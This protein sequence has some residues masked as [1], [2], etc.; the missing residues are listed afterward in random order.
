MSD[1]HSQCVTL[2]SPADGSGSLT[3][4]VVVIHVHRGVLH[5]GNHPLASECHVDA[6]LN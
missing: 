5:T 2:E 6:H 4:L 1:C 3:G